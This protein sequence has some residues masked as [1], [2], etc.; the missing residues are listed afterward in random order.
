MGQHFVGSKKREL[1]MVVNP[2]QLDNRIYYLRPLYIDLLEKERTE[3]VIR[4]FCD[5]KY[6]SW[7]TIL[8]VGHAK[9]DNV[10]HI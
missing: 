7:Q 5:G 9:R 3:K 8:N 1:K 4:L 10:S 2:D 6:R